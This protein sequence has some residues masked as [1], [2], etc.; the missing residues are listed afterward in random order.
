MARIHVSIGYDR[1]DDNSRARIWATL[2]RK[3]R[4]D[5]D[6]GG[7]EIDYEY[8]AKEYVQ[9]SSEVK[10]LQWNGREIRNAFQTA[11]ALAVYDSKT[12]GGQSGDKAAIPKVKE[13]HLKQV[14]SMSS[15]FKRYIT[16]THEGISDSDLAYRYGNRNDSPADGGAGSKKDF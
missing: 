3:L 4:E 12:A 7:Q 8:D 9:R 5:R 13:S 6:H 2:F 15:A 10:E 14:V 11:V 16:S 1:L